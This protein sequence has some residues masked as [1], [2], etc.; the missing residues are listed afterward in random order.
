MSPNGNLRIFA[1]GSQEMGELCGYR[2]DYDAKGRVCNVMP[3]G[4][5]DDEEYRKLSE[6]SSVKVMK[7]TTNRL[8]NEYLEQA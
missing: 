1:S 2:I 3:I 6:E 8:Y 5:L 4:A 7:F